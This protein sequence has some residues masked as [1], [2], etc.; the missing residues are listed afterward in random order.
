MNCPN[1]SSRE[2]LGSLGA[3]LLSACGGY[4]QLHICVH[5]VDSSA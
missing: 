5:Q 3:L 4:D 2:L 1:L